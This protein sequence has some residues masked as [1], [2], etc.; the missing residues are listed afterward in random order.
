MNRFFH[1]FL[2]LGL[3][4]PLLAQERIISGRDA[5]AKIPNAHL[6]RYEEYTKIPTFIRFSDNNKME[7]RHFSSFIVYQLGLS[8]QTTWLPINQEA[9]EWGYLH[10]R[11]RQVYKGVEVEG[12]MLMVQSKA[13]RLTTLSGDVFSEVNQAVTPTL[14]EKTALSKALAYV[15]AEKYIWEEWKDKILPNHLANLKEAPKGKLVLVPFQGKVAQNDW[16]LAW[17]FDVY[18]LKP[19]SRQDIFIDAATGEVVHTIESIH[20]ADVVGSANTQYSG[21]RP[22][23]TDSFTGGYRLREAGRSGVETYDMNQ[24]TDYNVAVDF[25]DADNNWNNAQNLDKSATDAHWGAEMFYDYYSTFHNRNSIDGNGMKIIS[26]VHYDVAYFNAFWNGQF[27]TLGDGTGN[28]LT[29]LD[30]V[31]HEFTHGVTGFSAGLIYQDESGALNESFSDIF[32][33]SVE[34]YARPNN[35]SWIIGADLG[36][37][38]AFRSMSNPYSKGDPDTYLGN[39]WKT[40]SADNGGVHSNSGVQNKW[41]YLLVEGENGVNDLGN[42]YSV[43]GLGF[44]DASKIA[45]RNLNTYLT[46]YSGYLDARF[47]SIQ[48]A[49]DIFGACSQQVISTGEAWYAVGVGT[50]SQA[51]VTADFEFSNPIFCQ[52]DTVYFYNYSSNNATSTWNFGDGTTAIANTP[53]VAHY[54]STYGVYDVQL[55]V[56]GGA[57]GAD[58]LRMDSLVNVDALNPCY[59]VFPSATSLFDEHCSGTL[60]DDGGPDF[61]YSSFANGTVIIQP[62]NAYQVNLDFSMFKVA[63]DDTLYVFDGNS[64]TAPIIGAYGGNTIPTS[65]QSS[66]GALSLRFRS[67][68]L[69]KDSGFVAHWTCVQPTHKPFVYFEAD[70]TQACDGVIHFKDLTQQAITWSWNFGDGTTSTTKN[71]VH[72][73]LDN[74]TYTVSLTAGNNFGAEGYTKIDYI[75]ISRPP[76]PM[77]QDV[78]IC[79]NGSATLTAAGTGGIL[80][81]F[82]NGTLVHTGSTLTTPV[83]ASP[84]SYKLLEYIWG[85]P[86][87]GGKA[88]NSGLGGYYAYDNRATVFDVLQPCVL[89]EVQVYAQGVGNRTFQVLNQYGSVVW[90]KTVMLQAGL[91]TVSLDFELQTMANAHI[92][93]SGLTDLY[94]NTLGGSYPYNIGNLVSI[95]NNDAFNTNQYYFFYNW[96]VTELPCISEEKIVTVYAGGTAPTANYTYTQNLSTFVFDATASTNTL[97]YNWNFGD[98]TTATGATPTHTYSS[99]GTYYVQFM[100]QNGGCT[101]VLTQTVAVSM[102]SAIEGSSLFL[103]LNI[104]PNPNEGTFMVNYSLSTPQASQITLYNA[105]GQVVLS[106]KISATS[107]VEKQLQVG[108]ISQGIY[109][110][111]I[112]TDKGSVSKKVEIR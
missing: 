1:A 35:A 20:E 61:D 90:E 98:G 38:N 104:Y 93:I 86:T 51:V 28:P 94:R 11:Y 53:V 57:C 100:A 89:R 97:T 66:T 88:D 68:D 74:G 92:K 7:K 12:S 16:R 71:P 106:E 50:P 102:L 111:N 77:V 79:G 62:T 85:S 108:G 96:K 46:P 23:V 99:Q 10:E 67:T 112:S 8:P 80:K 82:H 33:K 39:A 31:A 34:F 26:Y 69:F 3:T 103:G 45:Y 6:I 56:S 48:G 91:N 15:S 47:Y 4:M 21:V 87:I 9:D 105:L 110:L 109:Y 60:Y 55:I 37:L 73:Y 95:T 54:Y 83:I 75:T 18:A 76:K 25:E 59:Y 84:Y 49:I 14:S 63:F 2:F 64:I 27:A 58:T 78:Y 32:G 52:P 101:N 17:K 70:T 5:L 72:T 81:W 41:Y 24:S 65:L 19:M 13:G 42:T 107:Q 22:I 44:T 40:G 36:G 30:V 43:T 29:C